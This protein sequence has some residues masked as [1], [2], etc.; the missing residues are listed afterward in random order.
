LLAIATYLTFACCTAVA[1]PLLLLLLLPASRPP[2]LER[3]AGEGVPVSPSMT[4]PHPEEIMT[5]LE[6]FYKQYSYPDH[7][8]FLL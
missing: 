3:L 6:V 7:K 2:E 5:Q 1:A 8:C 4:G